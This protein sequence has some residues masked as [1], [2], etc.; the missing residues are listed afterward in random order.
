[1]KVYLNRKNG[2]SAVGEF[3]LSDK[4]LIVKKGSIISTSISDSKKF[5]GTATIEKYR[6]EYADGD[7][8]KKDVAF[9]SASTAANFVTGISTNGLIAWKDKDGK[10]L[11]MIMSEVDA[12]E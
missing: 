2:V 1:M 12:D 4:S 10:T 7:K 11:K 9:K 3:N 5:R 6:K 8:V